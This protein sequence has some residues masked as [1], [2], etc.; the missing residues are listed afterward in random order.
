MNASEPVG[1]VDRIEDRDEYDNSR[2][3][4][5]GGDR[6]REGEDICE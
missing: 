6:R 3:V 4:K 2:S 5:D 1:Y